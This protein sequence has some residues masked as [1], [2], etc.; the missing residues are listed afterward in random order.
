MGA[1]SLGARRRQTCVRPYGELEIVRRVISDCGFGM[2]ELA[3][4][5]RVR[6]N[7]DESSVADGVMPVVLKK[8]ERD[9]VGAWLYSLNAL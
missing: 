6:V 4:A 9:F 2:D 7:R 1:G 8:G 5:V 3:R